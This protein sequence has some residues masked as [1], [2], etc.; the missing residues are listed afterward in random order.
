MKPSTLKFTNN[1]QLAV[2][3]LDWLSEHSQPDS[4]KEEDQPHRSPSSTSDAMPRQ[5]TPPP[6]KFLLN[7][8]KSPLIGLSSLLSKNL[9]V[10]KPP[11]TCLFCR[12]RKIACG[13]PLPGKKTCRSVSLSL[14]LSLC[15]KLKIFS[16][17]CRKRSLQCHYPPGNPTGKETS[18]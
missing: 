9:P 17:Q 11:F 1:C 16:S 7:S 8:A 5:M 12:G 6:T 13:A 14:S 15:K 18:K 2:I 4:P 3:H 10:K